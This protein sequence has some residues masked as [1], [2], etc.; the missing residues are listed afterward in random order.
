MFKRFAPDEVNA[1]VYEHCSSCG[2]P[3]HEG[4]TY[5]S[6]QYARETFDGSSVN[7]QDAVVVTYFCEACAR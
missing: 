3:I 4:E 6:V 1:A 5:W 7:V 2:K